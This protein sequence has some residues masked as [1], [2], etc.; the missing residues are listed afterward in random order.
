MSVLAQ[1][2][3]VRLSLGGAPLFDDVSFALRRRERVCLVGANGAGKS[4]LM[5]MLAG[6]AAPDAGIVTYESGAVVAYAAQAPDFAAHATVRAFVS[7]RSAAGRV[8]YDDPPPHR[9]DAECAAFGIDPD[10][11]VANLSGGEMQRASLARAFAADGDLLLLDEPTN[12]LDIPAIQNLEARLTDLDGAALIISHDRRF[13]ERVSTSCLWLRKRRVAALNR[14]Y[15][16]FEDWADDIEREEARAADKLAVHLEAEEHWLRRGVTARRSR[17]EGRRRKLLEL[18][19][20]SARA[21]E[22]VRPAELK[23]ATG[24]RTSD[25]VIEAVGITQSFGDARV[26]ANASLKIMRGDRV[27]VIG[28][29]GAGKTTLLDILLKRRTPDAGLVRHGQNL[30]IA[31]VDQARDLLAPTD[32]IWTA[33]APQGGDQVMVHGR[34]QHVAGYAKKFMFGADMLRQPVHALSGGER[35]RL[36]LAVALAKPANLLVL[37]EPTN[38][39]DL[40]TLDA[41]E[42][43]LTAYDGTIILVSHDR[44][45]LDG[46]TTS[47]FGA[48]G[49]GRW[50]ETP[51]GYDDFERERRAGLTSEKIKTPALARPSRAPAQRTKLSYKDERRQAELDAKLPELNREVEAL[52]R[53]LEDSALFAQDPEGFSRAAERLA[54]A[55]AEREDGETEWLEIEE[56]RARLAAGAET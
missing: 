4:T 1:M 24:A 36:A 18:R 34:A 46:V 45:F 52:E 42:S 9:V 2:I 29:N 6:D 44:A 5:R 14:S 41:L 16:H 25:I 28:P 20:A 26:I 50:A 51:G 22:S 10:R 13:L 48:I 56:Q 15:A 47:I 55:R 12:H 23:A 17:N 54:Q 7:A 53:A 37:D 21:H 27:G 11:G 38:D 31:H 3:S 35:N 32:T 33:L 43:M 39:L 49:G 19:H 8:K 40:D 30:T